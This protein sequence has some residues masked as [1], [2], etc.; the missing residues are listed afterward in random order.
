MRAKKEYLVLI[1]KIGEENSNSLIRTSTSQ[2]CSNYVILA[3]N[4]AKNSPKIDC[5]SSVTN[6]YSFPTKISK[7]VIDILVS[8]PYFVPA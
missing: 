4:P 8:R 5:L 1:A 2:H 6:V 7:P 3:I